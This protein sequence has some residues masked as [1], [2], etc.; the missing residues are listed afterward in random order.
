MW[1]SF[2]LKA[3]KF[4]LKEKSQIYVLLNIQKIQFFLSKNISNIS[5]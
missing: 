3:K 5:F 1:F 2:K 4:T